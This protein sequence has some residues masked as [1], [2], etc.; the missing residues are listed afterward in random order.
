[1]T[2]IYMKKERLLYNY[3]CENIDENNQIVVT[4]KDLAE[5]LNIKKH[6]VFRWRK[7]LE[8]LGII[9]CKS[10]FIDRQKKTIITLIKK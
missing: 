9:E 7:L 1:M 3:I 5:S 10:K 6:R 4:D 8:S 2:D